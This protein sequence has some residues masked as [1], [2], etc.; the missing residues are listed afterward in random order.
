M[1]TSGSQTSL[2]YSEWVTLCMLSHFI[3]VWL[4]HPMDC[5]PPGSSVCGIPQARILEWVAMPSSKGSSWPRDRTSILMSPKFL[6]PLQPL[7]WNLCL[8]IHLPIWWLL[9]ECLRESWVPSLGQ[10]DPLEKEMATYSSI[11]AWRI[12]WTEKP[13]GLQSMGWQRVGH[14][15]ALVSSS[16]NKY[17]DK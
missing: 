11:L 9:H 1:I 16:I 8:Y 4:C 17:I 6:S 2:F 5:S 7:L 14:D 3:H 15:W 12:P 13:G 10:E